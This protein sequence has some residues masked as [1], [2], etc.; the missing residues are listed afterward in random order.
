MRRA[1][2]GL[3]LLAPKRQAFTSPF[4]DGSQG[5]MSGGRE[6]AVWS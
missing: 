6:W 2:L 4:L 5:A 3:L 1:E